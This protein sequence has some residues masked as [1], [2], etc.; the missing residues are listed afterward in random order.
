MARSLE[1]P[2]SRIDWVHAQIREGI[3]SR[4]FAPGQALVEAELAQEFG[5]SKTP[6]REALKLLS[7]SGLVVFEPYKGATVRV[8]TRELAEQVIGVRS[9]LEPAAV[10]LAVHRQNGQFEEAER[11]LVEAASLDGDNARAKLSVLNR[12][13]HSELYRYCGNSLMVETLD[14]LRDRMA[15]VSIQGWDASDSWAAEWD[16][17]RNILQAAQDGNAGLAAELIKKH[18]ESFGLRFDTMFDTA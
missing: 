15:L 3:L 2:A 16:E 5:V 4:E 11:L 9:V 8:P 14:G 7:S 6:V 18:I 10:E 13:F 17:H 12:R 1:I